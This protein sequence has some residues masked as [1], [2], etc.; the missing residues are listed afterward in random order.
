[1]ATR[2]LIALNC[3]VMVAFIIMNPGAWLVPD[4]QSLIQWGADYGLLAFTGQQWR[5]F[6]CMF[7]HVGILHLLV[8]MYGLW[9]VGPPAEEL[10]GW[11]ELIVIYV[12]SG[13]MGF[14][15]SSLWNPMLVSAGASGAIFGVYGSLLAFLF[16]QRDKYPRK[17]LEQHTLMACIFIGCTALY[18]FF[19]PEID[20]FAHFGGLIAGGFSGF[21]FAH[22]QV[23]ERYRNAFTIPTLALIAAAMLVITQTAFDRRGFPVYQQALQALKENDY[24][25]AVDALSLFLRL[26]PDSTEALMR[27]AL[28]YSKLGELPDAVRDYSRVLAVTPENADAY[29]NLAWTQC[30]LKQYEQAV[31]NAGD[32]IRLL[33][34]YSAAYD[35]RAYAYWHLGKVK[36][37]MADFQQAIKLAPRD[38]AAFYHRRKMKKD[39][40]LADESAN[41]TEPGQVA[42][43]TPDSW[44]N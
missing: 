35:T 37:A 25:G 28:A 34:R 33:P 8:N 1:M 42:Q 24:S 19:V 26:H 2:V 20:N 21:L 16:V 5:L 41:T 18:G 27:R 11:R 12:F 30:G 17:T 15:T 4:R 7:L 22:L 10:F 6:T 43:Y 31:E 9:N 13:V 23:K 36:E 44:E 3:L 32:C 14:M 29:N 38:S 39:L 40:N